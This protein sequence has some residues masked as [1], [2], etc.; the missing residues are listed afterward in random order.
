MKRDQTFHERLIPLLVEG[1]G[2][3]SYLELG[4]H[5]NETIGKVVCDKRVGVDVNAVDL[6]GALMFKMTTEE[7]MAENAAKLAPYDFVFIDANHELSA[8]RA[9]F[10]GIMPFV[11]PEGLVLLHDTNP[12]TV[13]DTASG[14]CADSWKFAWGLSVAGMEAVTLPFHP[15]LTIIRKRAAW[16]PTA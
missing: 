3:Q 16:G 13:A 5:Q 8:V 1:M 10:L 11:S 14:L 2:A 7:F 12:E 9:D 6:E 15:G 4:T